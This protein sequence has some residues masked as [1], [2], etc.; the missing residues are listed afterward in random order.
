MT[1]SGTAPHGEQAWAWTVSGML[2]IPISRRNV[3]GTLACAVTCAVFAGLQN[4]RLVEQSAVAVVVT[5]PAP[6][7]GFLPSSA[8]LYSE[9]ADS[10]ALVSGRLPAPAAAAASAE[11]CSCWCTR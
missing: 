3:V 9:A 7:I 2:S 8:E 10:A 6:T 4:L 1:S 5:V 11:A